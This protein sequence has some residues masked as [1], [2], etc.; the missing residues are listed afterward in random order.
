M[1]RL[2][3]CCVGVFGVYTTS[4]IMFIKCVFDRDKTLKKN[5]LISHITECPALIGQHL[6]QDRPMKKLI[7]NVDM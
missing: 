1:Y 4:I 6:T 5:A 7:Y 3:C 2:K